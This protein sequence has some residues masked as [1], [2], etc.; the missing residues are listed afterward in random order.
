MHDA[1]AYAALESLST[2]FE[3]ILTAEDALD[4]PALE[5][6]LEEMACESALTRWLVA[7]LCEA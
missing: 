1:N 2:Q 4:G 6:V 7:Q 5:K 3:H